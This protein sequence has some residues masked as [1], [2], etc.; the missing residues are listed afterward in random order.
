MD[1][2]R[3]NVDDDSNIMKDTRIIMD[4]LKATSFICEVSWTRLEASQ[5]IGNIM[6]TIER[7]M[8]K[9]HVLDD[10]ISI[11]DTNR[12]IIYAK[13]KTVLDTR[14][15]LKD[16]KSIMD[17]TKS[18]VGDPTSIMTVNRIA[19]ALRLIHHIHLRDPLSQIVFN[20]VTLVIFSVIQVAFYGTLVTFRTIL[21]TFST[22]HAFTF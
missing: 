6:D 7:I 19:D 1:L 2:V 16:I 10:N 21:V 15:V 12:I 14:S 5:M 3:N 22:F 9:L 17:D 20:N 11:M 4:I 8:G 18:N 13:Y